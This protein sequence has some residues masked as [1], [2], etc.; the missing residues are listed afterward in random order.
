VTK[1]PLR[2]RQCFVARRLYTG[3]ETRVATEYPAY[4]SKPSATSPSNTNVLRTRRDS[5]TIVRSLGGRVA[6][7]N[8]ALKLDRGAEI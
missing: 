4:A 2:S 7:P 6:H 3:P 8:P 1:K 5:A